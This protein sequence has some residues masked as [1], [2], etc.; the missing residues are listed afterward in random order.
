M[1]T[2]SVEERLTLLEQKMRRLEKVTGNSTSETR[3]WERISGAF[4]DDL[5]YSEAMKLAHDERQADRG[6]ESAE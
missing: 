5:I 4:K 6:E 3:W 2:D 1:S